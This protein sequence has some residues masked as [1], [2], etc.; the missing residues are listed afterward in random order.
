MQR[1]KLLDSPYP[2]LQPWVGSTT[3]FATCSGGG[4]DVHFPHA[5]GTEAESPQAPKHVWFHCAD[6]VQLMPP[7]SHADKPHYTLVPSL[8][9]KG[10]TV[11]AKVVEIRRT[12][13]LDCPNCA[14]DKHVNACHASPPCSRHVRPDG[15]DIIFITAVEQW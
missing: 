10:E 7:I 11:W 8:I 1:I 6:R 2:S 4:W 13:A 3:L 12:H 9:T 5:I 14:F 15:R